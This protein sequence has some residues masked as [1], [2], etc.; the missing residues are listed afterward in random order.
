MAPRTLKERGLRLRTRD[1]ALKAMA[2]F[3]LEKPIMPCFTST[4]Y[5]SQMMLSMIQ[6]WHVDG[7][8]LHLNRGCEGVTQGVLENRLALL[9]A[10]IPVMAYE[11]NMGDKRECNEAEVLDRLDAFMESL[12]LTRLQD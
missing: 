9:Q 8:I 10:G 7:V 4:E 5:K 1:D 3:Y 11:G 6:Q 2:E 12:G